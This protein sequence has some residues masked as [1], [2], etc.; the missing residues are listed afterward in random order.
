MDLKMLNISKNRNNIILYHQNVQSLNNKIDEL[1]TIMHKNC[2][3]PHF[4]CLTEHQMKET[5]ITNISLEGYTL[6][7]CFCRE[8]FRGGGVCIFT[9]KNLVFQKMDLNQFCDEKVMEICAVKLNFT[10]SKLIIFCV[11]RSPR[12]DLTAFFSLIEK[13]L[14]HLL[15]PTVMF[16]IC[17]DLNINLLKKSNE[18]TKLLTM[19]NTYNLTQVVD[20]PTRTTHNTE[21]LIDTIFVD[22]KIYDEVEIKPFVNGLSDHDAQIISLQKKN[23]TLPHT[24]QIRKSRLI[25]EQTINIFQQLLSD[26]TWDQVYSSTCPNETFNTFQEIFLRHYEASFPV[27]NIN[28]K[29]KQNNWITEGIR[30]S[31]LRKRKLYLQYRKDK[32]NIQLTNHYRAYCKIL[33]KVI[34]EAKKQFFQKQVALSSN[35]IRTAWNI[36][37]RNTGKCYN[38]NTITKINYRNVPLKNS[39]EIANAFNN[40]YTN[41][42]ANLKIRKGDMSKAFKMLNN[43]KLRNKTQM[44]IIP[45]ME[46][47][48][49]N[50]IKTLKSK[51]TAGYDGISSKVLKLC[52]SIISKPLTYIYNC[53][54][55]NGIFPE[56]C[57][58]AIVRP[59]YKKG[60]QNEMKNYRPI[61][62]LT[63]FSKILETIMF[64]R[65]AQHFECNK[66][67]N[68]VQ[69]GYRKDVHIDDAI[70]SLLNN[71]ITNLDQRRCVGGIFCDLTKAFDCVN[72]NILLNKLHY[73]GVRDT[74]LLWFKSYLENRKQRV[75]ISP[76]VFDQKSSSNWNVMANGVPQGSI[77]GPLLFIIY[78]NDLP[79]GLHQD[80]KPVIYAD[81]TSVLLTAKNEDELKNKMISALDYMTEWFLANGLA[82]NI[83]KT[84]IMKFTSNNL[85][86]ETFQITQNNKLI[87]ETNNTNFLGLE[88]DKN[89]N[90]KTHIKKILPKLSSSCYLIR[91]M[92]ASCNINTLKMIYF[93]YFHSIMEFGIIFWGVSMESKRIFIQQKRTVR[94]M[95]G[96][97]IRT[98]CRRLFQQL[99][100]L[101]LTSQYILSLMSFLSS[102]LDRFVF[103]SSVHNKNTRYRLK[104]HKPQANLKM[105]QRST[106]YNCIN[107]YNELPGELAN[108]ISDKK[109]FLR[110]L[111]TYLLDRPYYTLGEFLN[112]DKSGK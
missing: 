40:Y 104:L 58:L 54:L 67:L 71:T 87:K 28:H 110:K 39:S 94:I 46:A 84:N 102:N 65:L 36:I 59:I 1:S 21:T 20:F 42:I 2:I 62:L 101:T 93:A 69:F 66:I 86:D 89:L 99:R 63:S 13:I 56:R 78:L 5:E 41:I 6:A 81:D 47:E 31:C 105:F 3:G 57:K 70:F 52:A 22:K 51:N 88:L 25:N 61:S 103:N 76:N 35:K 107:I 48:V 95:T 9:Y 12:G 30:T 38:E 85:W 109:Q 53:S 100:I 55:I 45:V 44:K 73:Y 33:K 49:L 80:N 8:K 108:L 97:S 83:E 90:W 92:Y 29:L 37:K 4:V 11:Y 14:N 96:S 10:S 112:T 74:G 77:L 60:E 79:Y 19:M 34:Q 7:A 64:N 50:I 17:G 111:K 24:S 15:K 91:R 27:V 106:Y 82:L 32:D 98:S 43:L 23:V 72:H 16:L 75:S 26:E 68:S 18:A